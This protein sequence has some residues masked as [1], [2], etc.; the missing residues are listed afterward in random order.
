MWNKDI[1]RGLWW[2]VATVL[3]YDGVTHALTGTAW[4][5]VRG[6][7]IPPV[8]EGLPVVIFGIVEA[9]CGLYLG[10]R[11]LFRRPR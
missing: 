1:T 10:Y 9:V 5:R 8:S 2:A 7:G 6:M 4:G 11:F 3:V